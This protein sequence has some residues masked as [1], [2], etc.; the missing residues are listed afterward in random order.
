MS[1]ETGRQE[2]QTKTGQKN[3]VSLQPARSIPFEGL[4][5]VYPISKSGVAHPVDGDDHQS[6]LP[7]IYNRQTL[8][9]AKRNTGE[10]TDITVI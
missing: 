5:P 2:R 3:E 9:G 10:E 6:S 1:W 8:E 4:P 7:A